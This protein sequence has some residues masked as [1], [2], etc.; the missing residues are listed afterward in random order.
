MVADDII[1]LPVRQHAR[2]RLARWCRRYR[3]T[4][5]DDRDRHRPVG[6]VSSGARHSASQSSASLPPMEI[7]N[8]HAGF[9]DRAAHGM[10]R[11]GAVEDVDGGA[12]GLCQISDLRR[13]E[14][15]VRRHPHR[16]EHPCRKHRLQHGVGVARMQQNPVAVTHTTFSKRGGRRLDPVTK[17]LPGPCGIAPDD[18][19]PVGKPAG[20][21]DQQRSKVGGRDQRRLA[22]GSRRSWP[23][24]PRPC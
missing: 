1:H 20:G 21:L 9:S 4:R 17:R 8:R 22:P 5:R 18:R 14:P 16:A 13:G 10:I 19:R 12:G 2:L 6:S 23:P 3:R 7:S 24:P 15:K 11:E